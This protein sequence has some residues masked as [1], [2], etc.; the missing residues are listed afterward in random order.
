MRLALPVLVS[1]LC[2]ASGC[3]TMPFGAANLWVRRHTASVILHTDNADGWGVAAH[4]YLCALGGGRVMVTY[5]L[6]GDGELHGT[7]QVEWP[8]YSDDGGQTWI[9]GDPY[10]W[11]PRPSNYTATVSRGEVYVYNAGYCHGAIRLADGSLIAQEFVIPRK[12]PGLWEG[13][14]IWSADGAA[15][16]PLP[17][18]EYRAP[19]NITSDLYLSPRAVQLRDGTV[20]VAVYARI[21]STRQYGTWLFTSGDTG[22]HFECRSAIGT[23]DDVPW[24]HDVWGEKGP[25]EPALEVLAGGDLV[26]IMRTGSEIS[27]GRGA[28]SSVMLFA[29]SR[30][31]GRTWER[32]KFVAPGVM[33][34]L[35]RMSNGV[36]VCAFGRPGNNLIFSL[37]GGKTWGRETP[38]TPVDVLSSGYLDIAETRPGRLLVVYDA[39]DTP[40]SRFWLWEPPPP[41][42]GLFRTL[43]DVRPLVPISDR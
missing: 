10:T 12:E 38:I 1:A 17:P 11:N 18:V 37:D 35:L 21:N 13:A 20:A 31:D 5:G 42:N 4:P 33:P 34:K 28:R 24:A 43:V 30:D 7:A 6:S 29:R 25:C 26:S 3:A 16:E 41:A 14:G 15:W 8:L 23:P 40:P 9:H 32:K 27:S 36:L 19:T 22:R 2:L 39:F